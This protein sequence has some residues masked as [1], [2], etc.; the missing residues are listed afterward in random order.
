MPVE[1]KL[2]P[3]QKTL[4]NLWWRFDRCLDREAV[5]ISG[6]L[7][8]LSCLR[9]GCTTI[10]DHHSSPNYVSGSLDTLADAF[11]SLSMT[12]VLCSEISDRNGIDVFD[13][14]LQENLAFYERHQDDDQ[15]RGF[16]G[17]HASF[18]LGATS[19]KKISNV[20]PADAPVHVHVAEDI[21]DVDHA[22]D[23]NFEGPLLRLW[24]HGLLTRNSLIVHG[25][26]L[27]EKEFQ[28][29][30]DLDLR[31]VHNP[32]SNF[33]NSVGYPPM[34]RIH[35]DRLLLGTDG[36]SSNLLGA[37]YFTYLAYLGL[38]KGERAP[39]DLI[40][41]TLLQ[42]PA[43]Y[44][45]GV[46]GRPIGQIREGMLADFAIFDYESP[47]PITEENIMLHIL[48]GLAD[49][50]LASWVYARGNP[51]VTSGELIIE[52][53]NRTIQ[54]ARKKAADLWKRYKNK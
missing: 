1:E 20:L 48:Y 44:L 9:H 41:Q 22:R 33:N 40:S 30:E 3:F 14:T 38:G 46:F 39:V 47:T 4:E 36:M 49:R 11:S 24:H 37:A 31:L 10:I 23:Q 45:S 17:L 52:N 21:V 42:N 12:S 18:T 27:C 19:L 7:T 53:S 6:L 16:V 51:V 15:T 29:L 13:E 54:A 43:L 35:E 2:R 32:Q 28:L 5:Y 26:H 25:I 50:P 8:G 34:D